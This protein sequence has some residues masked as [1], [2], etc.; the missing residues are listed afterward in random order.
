MPTPGAPQD[1]TDSDGDGVYDFADQF[2][3]DVNN[4]YDWDGD[5]V[6]NGSDAND[7]DPTVQ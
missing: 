7:E 5:T 4:Q 3:N 2:P 1:L 6:G